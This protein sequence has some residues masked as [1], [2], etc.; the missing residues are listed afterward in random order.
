[1]RGLDLMLWGIVVIFGGGALLL[2][3]SVIREAIRCSRLMRG[4]ED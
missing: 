3:V 1:M 4:E 2:A